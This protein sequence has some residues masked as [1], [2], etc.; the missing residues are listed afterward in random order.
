MAA[1]LPIDTVKFRPIAMSTAR[2]G[3]AFAELADGSTRFV[4]GQQGVDRDSGLPTW[5]IDVAVPADEGDDRG[6]MTAFTVRLAAQV[7]P[8]VTPLAPVQFVDLV[9]RPAVG[10]RDGKL[11]IYWSAA[12]VATPG[13]KFGGG[14]KAA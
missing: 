9:A 1:S 8:Q 11:A 10:K 3:A 13:A 7:Q 2:P 14:E 6:R 12:G 4:P 5:E